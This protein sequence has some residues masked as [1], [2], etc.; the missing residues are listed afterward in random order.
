MVEA[1]KNSLFVSKKQV[2]FAEILIWACSAIS[3]ERIGAE[4]EVVRG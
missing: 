1:L 3:F 4:K 2:F